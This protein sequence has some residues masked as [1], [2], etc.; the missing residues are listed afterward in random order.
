ML[1]ILEL[2]F[3]RKELALSKGN[4]SFSQVIGSHLYLN[5]VAGKNAD[6]VLAH[7]ARDMSNNNVV[8]F[9]LYAESGVWK[10]IDN[11]SLKFNVVFFRHKLFLMPLDKNIY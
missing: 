2:P 7:L 1:S 11:L 4:T 8:I 9:Q 10:G 6:V 3:T 5:L